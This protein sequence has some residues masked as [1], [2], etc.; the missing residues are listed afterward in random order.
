MRTRTHFTVPLE[1]QAFSLTSEF[2]R[3]CAERFSV[4]VEDEVRNWATGGRY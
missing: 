1:A 4:L 2:M 3:P